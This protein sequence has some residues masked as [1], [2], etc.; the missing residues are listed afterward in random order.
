LKKVRRV[1]KA[2]ACPPCEIAPDRQIRA[3]GP[4]IRCQEAA[5]SR[6]FWFKIDYF[7]LKLEMASPGPADPAVA[8][9][10]M[11]IGLAQDR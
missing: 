3:V 5:R 1:G 11:T 7:D 8:K 10:I 4:P 9:R 6:E 2:Q